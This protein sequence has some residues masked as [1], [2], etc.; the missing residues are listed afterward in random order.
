[1][2]DSDGAYFPGLRALAC[3]GVRRTYNVMDF[4]N[5]MDELERTG[6]LRFYLLR[7]M[8]QRQRA[9]A[10]ALSETLSFNPGQPVGRI[11][12]Q[13]GQQGSDDI[14]WAIVVDRDVADLLIARGLVHV[15]DEGDD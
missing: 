8:V 13:L 12:E 5:I 1:M 14:T 3:D 6:M 15:V 10:Q 7:I 2:V 11:L 9:K 4:L